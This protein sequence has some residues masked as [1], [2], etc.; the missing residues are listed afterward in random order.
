M[1]FRVT[2]NEDIE[3][4]LGGRYDPFEFVFN[5]RALREFLRVSADA[6]REVDALS[7]GEAEA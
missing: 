2:G 4:S 7:V 1:K 5:A 3:F 6:L